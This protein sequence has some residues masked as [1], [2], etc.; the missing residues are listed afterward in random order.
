M[1]AMALTL[2][3]AGACKKSPSIYFD[4]EKVDVPYAGDSYSIHFRTNCDW[5]A[6][7][8]DEWIFVNSR[9]GDEEMSTLKFQVS[10][11]RTPDE[12]TG[13]ITV[14]GEGV[15]RKLTVVQAPQ[16]RISLEGRPYL[17]ITSER[18]TFE[19]TVGSN[20]EFDVAIDV[21]WLKDVTSRSMTSTSFVF[22]ALGNE[23][24]SQR[25]GHITF[26][27]RENNVKTVFTVTQLGIQQ[28]VIVVHELP[29]FRI[30]VLNGLGVSGTVN[31]GDGSSNNYYSALRHVYDSEGEHT[32]MV[33]STGASTVTLN[34]LVGVVSV[35]VTGF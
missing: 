30:P 15:S 27:N 20:V 31:W 19:L 2:V 28:F 8:G 12:R 11:N 17:D 16:P 5:V 3:L 14:S 18:Q 13:Y 22:E 23:S 4:S 10:P 1:I 6:N 35:D 9:N 29:E 25:E 7:T 21:A 34:D 32:V 24:T 33:I 26:A